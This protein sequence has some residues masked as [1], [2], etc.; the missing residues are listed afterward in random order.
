MVNDS[1]LFEK[2]KKIL[3]IIRL[4]IGFF[5]MV[6]L[7]YFV[8]AKLVTGD[9]STQEKIENHS[10]YSVKSNKHN[11]HRKNSNQHKK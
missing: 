5:I 10:H 6:F 8:I 11:T 9:M 7:P 1:I 3:G 2:M 4:I